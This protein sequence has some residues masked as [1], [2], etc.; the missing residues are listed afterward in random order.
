MNKTAK[1][2]LVAVPLALAYPAAAWVMGQQIETAIGEHY[3][4][5]AEN[6]SA[7]I[8]S[9][10]YQRGVFSATET[11]TIELFSNVT[12]AVA[13]QQQ[14]AM[15]AN[16]G[17]K[18]PPVKPLQIAVRSVIRHGPLPGFSKLAAAVVDSELV[19]DGELQ[20]QVAAVFGTQKPLEVHSE[21]R[22]DGGGISTV[23]S[24]G[25]STHWA[26]GEGAGRNTLVWE[27]L[28]IDVDFAKGLKSYTLQAE[29]PKLT[30]NDSKGGGMSMNDMRLQ[31][32]QQ[33]LFEDDPL[34]YVGEQKM[35][36]A[37]LGVRPV[38]EADPV[39]L[40]Q[41]VYDVAMPVS[42]EY[43]DMIA[44]LGAASLQVGK[45]EFGPA[46][47]DFSLR[48]L[49]GRT[50]AT[51][52]RTLV[53]IYGDPTLSMAAGANPAQLWAP[54]AKPATDLLK[55]APE[56]RLD[57]LSFRSPHGDATLAARVA[58]K[59]FAETDLANPMLLVAKLD[60]AA[61]IALPEALVG[62]MA[63]T[64]P[65][66]SRAAEAAAEN[67][68][69]VVVPSAEE[70]AEQRSEKLRQQLSLFIEQGLVQREGT[71]IKSKLAFSRGQM[72]INGKPFNPMAMGAPGASGAPGGP[73]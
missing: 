7:K 70:L 13:R 22:F 35:T 3:Q 5:L 57:R 2:A 54:V 55:H 21:Y 34:L 4:L 52:Y 44:R 24:P 9:R 36:L 14:E 15:A 51:L 25:F 62:A 68:E 67:G 6:P 33:R 23:R 48:H 30:I 59:D 17:V 32:T 58:L 39:V 10:D 72:T 71:Q 47:Y 29:A 31:A 41:V 61:E 28:R 53:K 37:Q 69:G 11:V 46:N 27:G 50:L 43:V 64:L 12:A 38:K 19:L 56:F 1:I 65:A 60:A 66:G 18:L 26:A 42:G 20:Q 40:K 63:S 49:H 16:P 45:Q 8:V 73:M